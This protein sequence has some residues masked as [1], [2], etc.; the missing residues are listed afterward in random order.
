MGLPGEAILARKQGG[1]GFVRLGL[2]PV[3][4]AGQIVG[5]GLEFPVGPPSKGL[6]GNAEILL[7]R[8]GSGTCQR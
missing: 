7:K 2:V 5:Q 1:E 8:M 6:N 4:H 3:G